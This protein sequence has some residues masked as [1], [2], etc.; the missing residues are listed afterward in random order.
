MQKICAMF[1]ANLQQFKE[2]AFQCLSCP[3][4]LWMREI[5]AARPDHTALAPAHPGKCCLAECCE[6][7]FQTQQPQLIFLR[8]VLATQLLALSWLKN[9]E[10]IHKVHPEGSKC[11]SPT[12]DHKSEVNQLTCVQS[13]GG[14]KLL[15][16]EGRRKW[17]WKWKSKGSKGRWSELGGRVLGRVSI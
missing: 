2:N 6:D 7:C 13:V 11:G 14:R 4:Q 15:Q 5:I 9:K 10:N 1:P 17:K 16:G 12:T 3:N 8:F